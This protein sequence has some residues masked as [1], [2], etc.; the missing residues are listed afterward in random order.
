M[1][2]CRHFVSLQTSSLLI[3]STRKNRNRKE[4]SKFPPPGD[5]PPFCFAPVVFCCSFTALE[6]TL[7][8]KE[9]TQLYSTC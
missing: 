6:K 5:T 8:E 2:T 1:L 7:S 4:N 9:K 3:H